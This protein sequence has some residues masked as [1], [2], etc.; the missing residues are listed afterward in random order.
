MD[1]EVIFQL[2]LCN[3]RAAT[4]TLHDIECDGSP[5]M[6][7]P[8]LAYSGDSF[9]VGIEMLHGI[10]KSIDI[11]IP[12]RIDGVQWEDLHP[13]DLQPLKFSV[14]DAFG[15]KHQLKVPGD[16]LFPNRR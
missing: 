6:F 15:Q 5:V 12:A 7:N 10:G 14:I 13:I 9:P 4:T 8:N 16:R 3:H 1:S 2:S 11:A